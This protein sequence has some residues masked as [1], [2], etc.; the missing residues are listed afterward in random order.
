MGLIEGWKTA[1][2]LYSVQ[3]ATVIAVLALVQSTVLPAYELQL[4][5]EAYAAVNGLL[6]AA[7]AVVRLIKQGPP[8]SL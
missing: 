3:L 4:G 6:A 7:L 5:A 1:Y 8:A 2:K